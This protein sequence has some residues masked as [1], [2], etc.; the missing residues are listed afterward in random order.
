MNIADA[1]LDVSSIWPRGDDMILFRGEVLSLKT[2]EDGHVRCRRCMPSDICFSW[3][4]G[5]QVLNFRRK[6]VF[7]K[8]LTP[9]ALAFPTVARDAGG[10]YTV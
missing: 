4:R 3:P 2:S 5:R 8:F 7:W 1:I 9:K 10:K 6:F